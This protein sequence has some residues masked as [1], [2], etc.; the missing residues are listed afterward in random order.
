[1]QWKVIF[2]VNLQ[3]NEINPLLKKN[4]YGLLQLRKNNDRF[5]LQLPTKAIPNELNNIQSIINA[6]ISEVTVNS[7]IISFALSNHAI[8]NSIKNPTD[9]SGICEVP[10]KYIVEYSSPNI[11]KP[12]HVGHL[13]STIIGNFLSN[14]FKQ[15]NHEVIQMNYL[16]DYGTQFG[17]LK[18]GIDME[19]LSDEEIKRNPLQN[20]LRVYVLANSSK[21]PAIADKARKIFEQMEFSED[22]EVMNQWERIRQYT[23]DEL[24]KIYHRLNVNFDVYEFE[25]MYRRKEIE[26]II[27]LMDNKKLIHREEDGKQT[28]LVGDRK[29][30]FIKSDNTTLYLTRD[31]AAFLSR[32]DKY[33]MDKTFYVVDNGQHDHFMAIKSVIN[34]LDLNG[35]EHI[36]HVK[37]GRI[38]GM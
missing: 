10:H 4:L 19:N 3:I 28:V 12:F 35:D 1:M 17:F 20:L 36:S 33:E 11:A 31:I 32:W 26:G 34:Q 24:A 23:M 29:V 13:R 37:F 6:D 18:A 2:Y 14:I 9:L 7:S 30:S 15:F 21:D 8:K 25:S 38:R 5:E 27:S 22:T 16:G